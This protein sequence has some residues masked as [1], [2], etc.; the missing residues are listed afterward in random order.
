[1]LCLSADDFETYANAGDH[2]SKFIA[3]R[4]RESISEINRARHKFIFSMPEYV[5]G[6]QFDTV[7]LIDVNQGEIDEGITATSSL[8]KFISQLYLGASRAEKNLFISS[9]VDKGGFPETIKNTL[10][11]NISELYES[12]TVQI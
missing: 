8:R 7:F 2:K 3:I 12:K 10:K 6:L 9:R 1:V 4:D 5:A 11:N